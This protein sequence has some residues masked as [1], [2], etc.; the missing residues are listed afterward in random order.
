[1][2]ITTHTHSKSA[3]SIAAPFLSGGIPREP[4]HPF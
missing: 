1:M 2:S 4:G 3:T